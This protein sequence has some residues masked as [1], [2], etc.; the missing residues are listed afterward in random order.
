MG[1]VFLTETEGRQVEE[2]L[3][4]GFEVPSAPKWWVI[5]ERG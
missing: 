3:R 4:Y 1:D 2:L 5:R